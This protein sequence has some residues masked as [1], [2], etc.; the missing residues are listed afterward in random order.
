MPNK[1]AHGEGTIYQRKDGSWCAQIRMPD[2]KRRTK[3][4]KAQKPVRDWL[5]AQRNL[6]V[7]GTW[8]SAGKTTLSQFLTRYLDDVAA[9][10]LRATTLV[11]YRQIARTHILP[12][13]GAYKLDQLRPE[14]LQRL[15]G[16]KL[17]EGKSKRTVEYIHAV[18]HRAL[19]QAVRWDVLSRNVA[20]A[21][22]PP[23]PKHSAP[24]MLSQ[25]QAKQLLEVSIGN[26]RHCIYILAL[27][28]GMRQGEILGLR[29]SDLDLAAGTLQV[30][31]IATA[32]KGQGVIFAEPKT[33]Q[34][35]R[36]VELPQMTLSALAN[37]R[38]EQAYLAASSGWKDQG[39]VF[40]GRNGKPQY[41]RNLLREFKADLKAAGLPAV[42]FHS[43][44]HLH[45]TLLMD[46]SVH[47]KVVQERLGHSRIGTTMDIYSHVLP[48]MQ[49][50][51]V[52][53][54]QRVLFQDPPTANLLPAPRPSP[55]VSAKT[56][57]S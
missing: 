9:H 47:P 18:L 2:G 15:Y 33:D 31:Q 11:T 50:P 56:D 39:L 5:L 20:D 45:A 4:D 57:A 3:Y 27:T 21:V 37:H 25:T 40:P 22:S 49:R 28:T 10:T 17:D 29:W 13:L 24:I 52:D 12:T 1:R 32:L 36:I 51:A 55:D 54:I 48:G 44:R 26:R 42:N 6:L 8:A 16:E 30:N 34:S 41:G 23:R 38:A 19:E 14:H 7:A 43:L 53:A 35:R 46:A